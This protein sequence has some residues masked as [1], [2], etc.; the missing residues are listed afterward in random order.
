M[1]HKTKINNYAFID[2]N[3][4]YLGAKS[5]NIDIHYGDLRLYLRNRFHVTQAFLFIGYDPNNNKLYKKLQSYGY[6][7]I[8]KPTVAYTENGI[9][10]MKGNVDAELVLHA[11]AIEYNEY[12]KAIIVSSDGDFTCLIQYLIEEDKLAKIIAP[13]KFYSSLFHPYTK[14]ILRL[15]TFKNQISRENH[16]KKIATRRIVRK[17]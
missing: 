2:G 12:D 6:I 9:R 7:I 1:P 16:T 13:T 15:D 3:N 14:H 17:H 5:Q 11:A 4:L 10:T 8:F